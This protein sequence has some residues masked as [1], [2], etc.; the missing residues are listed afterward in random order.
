L[1]ERRRK[2]VAWVGSHVLPH[3]PAVRRW[4]RRSLVSPHDIDDLVQEAYSRIAGLESVDH[5][6]R[7][8][9]YFFQVVRMLLA[10]QVRRSK[11]VRIESTAEIELLPIGSDDPSPEQIAA[12][13]HEWSRMQRE[14]AALPDRCRKIFELRKIHGMPQREIARLLG[15]SEGTVENDGAKATRLL[16]KAM[17]QEEPVQPAS[18]GRRS[19]GR[20]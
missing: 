14:I 1:N 5:I 11:I 7:P 9:A 16:L 13:R 8:E 19:D 10:E 2:L 18:Q 15:V 3:E 17:R 12:A 4:L 20:A 6:D